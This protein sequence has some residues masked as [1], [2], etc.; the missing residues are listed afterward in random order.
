MVSRIV[1]DTFQIPPFLLG[2]QLQ[3]VPHKGR[4]D[5]GAAAPGLWP[6]WFN[7]C[8]FACNYMKHC[9]KAKGEGLLRRLSIPASR[10]CG[11]HA[12]SSDP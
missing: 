12:A 8:M 9:I 4:G 3:T 2:K 10:L 7:S 5:G 6:L 11:I 1:F